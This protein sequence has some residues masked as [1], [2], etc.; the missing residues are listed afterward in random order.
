VSLYRETICFQKFISVGRDIALYMYEDESE[1]VTE[2][3]F[4]HL[5]PGTDLDLEYWCGQNERDVFTGV[6]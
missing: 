5:K 2:H 6:R 4:I 1:F 3:S